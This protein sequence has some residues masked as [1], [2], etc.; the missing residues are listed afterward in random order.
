M[1]SYYGRAASAVTCGHLHSPAITFS[2]VSGAFPPRYQTHITNMPLCGIFQQFSNVKKNP[3]TPNIN[4]DNLIYYVRI[5][6]YAIL[7]E[8]IQPLTTYGECLIIAI[9]PAQTSFL[10]AHCILCAIFFCLGQRWVILEGGR[11]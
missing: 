8:T 11:V 5:V 2:L 9:K 6:P 10:C 1:S 3:R 4:R 7:N